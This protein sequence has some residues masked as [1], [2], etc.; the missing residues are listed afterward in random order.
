VPKRNLFLVHLN[1][2][3]AMAIQPDGKIVVVGEGSSGSFASWDFAVVR[4]NPDG[5]LDSSFGGTGIVITQLGSDADS[6]SSVAIQADGKIVV[7]G[8]HQNCFCNEYSFALV[9]YNPNGTL[10]TSF[11]GTGI[12][13]TSVAASET[14][15]R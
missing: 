14:L 9:R 4:Y 12:V 15:R 2:A 6:A 13:I 10:D 1:G 7:A 11:N 8:I 5:S 3:A